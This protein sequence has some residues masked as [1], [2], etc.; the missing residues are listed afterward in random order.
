MTGMDTLVPVVHERESTAVFQC[1]TENVKSILGPLMEKDP[2]KR[3]GA[4]DGMQEVMS[5]PYWKDFDW[6][7]MKAH[8]LTL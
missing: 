6:E 4:K 1:H 7:E 8:K 5:H 3:L 2:S